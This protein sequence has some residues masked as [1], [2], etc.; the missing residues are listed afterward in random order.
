MPEPKVVN[1]GGK[2]SETEFLLVER[3][4]ELRGTTVSAF[5]RDAVLPVA[6]ETILMNAIKAPV[7]DPA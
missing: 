4:V 5:I 1:L 7:G 6:R 3:A 2:C